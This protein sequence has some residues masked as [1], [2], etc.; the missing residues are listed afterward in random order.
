MGRPF[1]DYL[2]AFRHFTVGARDRETANAFAELLEVM[3]TALRNNQDISDQPDPTGQLPPELWAISQELVRGFLA[4]TE[5]DA[6]MRADA[7]LAADITAA[8]LRGRFRVRS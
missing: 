8:M 1:D 7:L 2:T 4:S 5:L 3:A 6:A